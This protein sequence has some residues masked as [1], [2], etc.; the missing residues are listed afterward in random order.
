[1]EQEKRIEQLKEEVR[2]LAGG[3]MHSSGVDDLPSDIAEQ[4]LQ[5][6]IA[7][8]TAPTTTD[9]DLLT[10]DRVPLPPPDEVSDREI[11]VVLWQVIFGLARHR[12]F[13]SH[14]NHLS[15]RELYSVLWHTVLREE[16]T[17]MPEGDDGAYHVDVP[18]DDSE[19]TN[20]LTYYATE[21]DREWWQ[22]D[23]PDVALPPRKQPPH[24]R[25]ED[26]PRAEDDPQC[27]E[28]REW[29]Q[30]RRNPSAFAANRFGATANALRFVEELYGA[31]ASCVIVDHIMMLPH[32]H[33]EPYAD[34]LIVVFPD[35][36]RR[37]AIFDLVVHQGRPDTIDDK[38]EMIDQGR[39]SV[40]LWWDQPAPL[41]AS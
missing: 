20:Y 5:R 34:E 37:H 30:A 26:I 9:F 17:I 36:G 32:D 19:S 8:E 16:V 10:A 33:G 31:G 12:V 3:Q 1:M 4:F 14:T 11:G 29:L 2:R 28:A 23:A 13:L 15:D 21:K 27:A 39:G 38:Q 25:D 22:R 7:F 41:N 6:V 24:D 40:R 18:G 35:D